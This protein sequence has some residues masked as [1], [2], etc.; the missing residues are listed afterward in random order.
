MKTTLTAM[1]LV[2]TLAGCSTGNLK[3][4][5][6]YPQL[7]VKADED[8]TLLFAKPNLKL[9]QYTKAYIAPIR[10]QITND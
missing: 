8:N 1:A 10:V 5:D 4:P 7:T 3:A 9:G 6:S 2:L